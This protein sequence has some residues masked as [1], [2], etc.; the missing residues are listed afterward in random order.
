MAQGILAYSPVGWAN[1]LTYE[2]KKLIHSIMQI[3]GSILAI[4]GSA[5]QMASTNLTLETPHGICGKLITIIKI[6]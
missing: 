4:A 1:H 3:C 2:N 5:V 6:T